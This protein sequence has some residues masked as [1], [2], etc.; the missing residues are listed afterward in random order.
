MVDDGVAG[1]AQQL[2]V[3]IDY[4]GDGRLC[5]SDTMKIGKGEIRVFSLT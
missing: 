2:V 5:C 1:G 3:V 4:G